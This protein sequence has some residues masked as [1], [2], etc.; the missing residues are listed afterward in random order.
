MPPAQVLQ[1]LRSLSSKAVEP[2]AEVKEDC[3]GLGVRHAV[4]QQDRHLGEGACCK[5]RLRP[6]GEVSPDVDPDGPMR[7]QGKGDLASMAQV[8]VAIKKRVSHCLG[9]GPG[10]LQTDTMRSTMGVSKG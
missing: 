5:E 4:D 7:R 3:A 9:L 6:G 2:A 8:G 1:V 10:C